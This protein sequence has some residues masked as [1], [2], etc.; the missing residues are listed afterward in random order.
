MKIEE[1]EKLSPEE[2]AIAVID[3]LVE[4]GFVVRRVILG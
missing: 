2:Q 4:M 3:M 1:F